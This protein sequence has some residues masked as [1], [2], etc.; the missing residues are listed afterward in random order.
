MSG[1]MNRVIIMGNLTSDPTLR[2]LES[3]SAVG[4]L[5]IAMTESYRN[6]QGEQVE[7]TC[8]VDV[9]VWNKNAES[10]D[11]YL[12]KGSGVLV[13]GRLQLDQWTDKE[14]QVRKKLR[15]KA[16]RVQ[17]VDP[18]PKSQSTSRTRTAET[19]SA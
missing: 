9:A 4:E 6:R 11:K 8:Y 5:G 3:G 18:P 2:R 17:F 19:V 7:S 13:E 12:K 15:V 16:D 10:C 1:S 14:G